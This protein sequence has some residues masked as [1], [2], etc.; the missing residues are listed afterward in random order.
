[1]SANKNTGDSVIVSRRDL[2]HVNPRK[3]KVKRG[4]N[5]RK[6]MGNIDELTA[7]IIQNGVQ[8]PITVKRDGKVLVV[9]NGERRLRACMRAIKG[10]HDIKSIPAIILRRGVNEIEA[11]VT[12][13]VT[14][15]GKALE[16]VEEA[17]AFRRLMDWGLT[18]K[19]IAERIGKSYA[20]VIE[21]IKL[22]DAGPQLR[23][24][25]TNKDVSIRDASQIV[26][27]TDGDLDRQKAE[28]E[29]VKQAKKD[30]AVN[31]KACDLH[32]VGLLMDRELAKWD[33]PTLREADREAQFAAAEYIIEKVGD[34]QEAHD[35]AY[36]GGEG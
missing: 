27:K 16:P 11:M 28:T 17:D 34:W 36:Q 15:D 10:G 14:N 29:K 32:K 7:S 2:M 9:V 4:W 35:P 18:G 5:P 33:G 26:K 21:R 24:A 31:N 19:E 22:V 13:L 20:M 8:V 12:T 3:L 25:V 30:K 1:M 6:D 23:Q